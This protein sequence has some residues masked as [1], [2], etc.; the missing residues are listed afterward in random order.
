M[1]ILMLDAIAPWLE[2][3]ARGLSA[4]VPVV[5]LQH[6][7]ISAQRKLGLPRHSVE[8]DLTYRTRVFPPGFAG[9]LAP[10]FAPFV[11]S[12]I[13]R[14]MARLGKAGG[15]APHV[16]CPF[17]HAERWTRHIPGNRLIYY[18][19]DEYTLYNPAMAEAIRAQEDRLIRR[20]ELTIC[21]AVHQ[22]QQFRQ[23]HPDVAERIHHL[24]HGLGE[25]F[26]NPAPQDP[27]TSGLVGYVGNL[28]DRVDWDFVDQVVQLAPDLTFEFFGSAGA[29]SAPWAD[30]RAQV[31]ARSNVRAPGPLPHS[32]V[33]AAYWHSAVNWMPY[34]T[35]HPF[36]VA[37]S[38]TKIFD[39]MGSGRPFV[40]T[41]I[42]DVTPYADRIQIA[43]SPQEAA[44]MLRQS[45][46]SH[47]PQTAIAMR[48]MARNH[49]WSSRGEQ[50]LNL[51]NP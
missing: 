51:L 42:P 2:G 20:A 32:E 30:L 14:E 44:A 10:L 1:S 26:L 47:D 11:R 16:I 39:S 22:A 6:V 7:S 25:N 12:G 27:P 37:A 35:D 40:S 21:V 3:L 8:G 4:H 15:A 46:A 43:R 31:F 24:P 34:V 48:D 45:A 23:R 19:V 29:E 49:L 17:P 18:N 28:G 9:T 13:E 50:L 36:N 33:P 5:A 41:A 38:P